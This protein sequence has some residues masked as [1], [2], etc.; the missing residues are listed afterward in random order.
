MARVVEVAA[1]QLGPVQR[2]DSRADVVERML[3]LLQV[4]AA[5]GA[6]LVAYPELGLTTFFPRRR[7]WAWASCWAS[8][9]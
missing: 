9:S 3:V 6:R 5:R 2:G 4:A 1:A 7:G 8:P